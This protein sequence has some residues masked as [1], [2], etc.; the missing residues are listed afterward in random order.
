MKGTVSSLG[1]TGVVGQVSN[2]GQNAVNNAQVARSA[3]MVARANEHF[4]N[5]N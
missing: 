5:N 1:T 4:G 3:E 2:I